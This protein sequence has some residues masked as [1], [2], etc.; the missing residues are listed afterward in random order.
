MR[1]YFLRFIFISFFDN[2]RQW[3]LLHTYATT[4]SQFEHFPVTIVTQAIQG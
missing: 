3:A 2:K 1:I 4:R